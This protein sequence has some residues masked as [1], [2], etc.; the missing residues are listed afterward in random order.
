MKR[1]QPFLSGQEEALI[2]MGE[3]KYH[4]LYLSSFRRNKVKI[5]FLSKIKTTTLILRVKQSAQQ[6]PVF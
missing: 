5:L 4:H 2:I 1:V 6:L 3:V